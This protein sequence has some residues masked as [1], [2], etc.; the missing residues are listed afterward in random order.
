MG[1]KIQKLWDKID[2]LEVMLSE[3]PELK[4]AHELCVEIEKE[5]AELRRQELRK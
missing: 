5:I 1:T 4:E 3:N 2:K